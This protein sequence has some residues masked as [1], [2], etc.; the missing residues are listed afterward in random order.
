MARPKPSTTTA[1]PSTRT[2]L[3]NALSPNNPAPG[4]L[5]PDALPVS[6][7]VGQSLAFLELQTAIS[8]RF[9]L[10]FRSLWVFLEPLFQDF[11]KV[12]KFL[13]CFSIKPS[14]LATFRSNSELSQRT[15]LRSVIHVPSSSIQS[16]ICLSKI[17]FYEIELSIKFVSFCVQV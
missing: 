15:N 7:L 6:Q 13:V 8:R 11:S 10:F 4:S 12:V 9:D 16:I 5:P 1:P 14:F 17:T 2:G 3:G